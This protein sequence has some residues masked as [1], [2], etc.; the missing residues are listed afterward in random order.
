VKWR[1][2]LPVASPRFNASWLALHIRKTIQIKNWREQRQAR[3]A[4]HG[5]G[6][7]ERAWL[8]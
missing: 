6:W 1:R 8:L 7:F 4:L 3:T 2:G 5:C